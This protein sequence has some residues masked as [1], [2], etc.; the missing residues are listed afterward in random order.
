MLTMCPPS[1]MCGMQS[2]VIR[3]TP[4]TFVSIIVASSSSVDSQNG[5][6]PSAR[7]AL[8]TRTSIP[9]RS[10]TARSTNRSQ[11]SSSVTSRSNA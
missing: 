1:R 4:R 11:L 6:R 2:R 8:L 10:A 9:P 3:S 5:S 7:P